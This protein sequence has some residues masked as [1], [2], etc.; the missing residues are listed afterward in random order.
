[1]SKVQTTINLVKNQTHVRT[2][3]VTGSLSHDVSNL[4]LETICPV[5]KMRMQVIYSFSCLICQE[6]QMSQYHKTLSTN[7]AFTRLSQIEEYICQCELRHLNLD[8]EGVWNRVYLPAARITDSLGV[9]K[10]HVKF[11]HV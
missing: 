3:Q 7:G 11:H 6:S 8:D 9:Y 10:G 2:Y 4:I 5:I 1:M